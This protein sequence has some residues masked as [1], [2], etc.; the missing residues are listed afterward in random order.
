MLKIAFYL[1]L[2]WGIGWVGLM[3]FQ[4]YY[5]RSLVPSMV[6]RR[7]NFLRAFYTTPLKFEQANVLELTTDNQVWLQKAQQTLE[8]QGYFWVKDYTHP[9][10]RILN[11]GGVH[12]NCL[13]RNKSG[14][15]F[16][17][18]SVERAGLWGLSFGRQ[19]T[20]SKRALVL[21]SELSDDTLV[22]TSSAGEW[23]W[24]LPPDGMEKQ[25]VNHYVEPLEILNLHDE[26]LA[27]YT[28]T[29]KKRPKSFVSDKAVEDQL[30]RVHERVSKAR[31]AVDFISDSEMVRLVDN[32]RLPAPDI[33]C[34]E[35]RRLRP[36]M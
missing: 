26:R 18:L 23:D 29:S 33:I 19:F 27:N 11:P 24:Q 17:T 15:V 34:E 10:Y 9:E 31:V 36:A 7:Y 20:E 13:F 1:V 5:K 2:L 21:T 30:Q 4:Q 22:V 14:T 28:K 16:A 35:L 3:F 32:P 8:S 12:F 6:K 25:V